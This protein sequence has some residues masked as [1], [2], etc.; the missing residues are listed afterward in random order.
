MT[1]QEIQQV[2]T[3]IAQIK[4]Q[5]DA[6]VHQLTGEKVQLNKKLD[7]EIKERTIARTDSLKMGRAVHEIW[8]LAHTQSTTPPPQFAVYVR[9][10]IDYY[11]PDFDIPF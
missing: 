2:E 9:Q 4:A 3:Y 11:C 10:I 7:A 8:K 6:L 1:P 5:H